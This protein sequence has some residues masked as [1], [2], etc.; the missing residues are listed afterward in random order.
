MNK[1]PKAAKS[2]TRNAVKKPALGRKHVTPAQARRLAAGHARH[3][4]AELFAA[5]MFTSA[6]V[7]DGDEVNCR[8][9]VAQRESVWLVFPKVYRDP[10][11]ITSS[12][13][14]AVCKRTGRV[15]Y[16]GSAGDEG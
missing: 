14:V 13:V 10:I 5:E 3:V 12:Y 8:A 11:I 9:T 6:P 15:H 1:K 7:R 16:V 4:M 2:G